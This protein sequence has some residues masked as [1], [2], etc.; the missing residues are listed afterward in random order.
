MVSNVHELL[1]MGKRQGRKRT[2]S[3]MLNMALLAP[4]PGQGRGSPTE[5]IRDTAQGAEGESEILKKFM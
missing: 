1:G 2:P 4:M 5:R 3:M